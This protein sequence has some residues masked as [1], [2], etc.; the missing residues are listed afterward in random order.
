MVQGLKPT[1]TTKLAGDENLPGY[2]IDGC[3]NGKTDPPDC[4]TEATEPSDTPYGKRAHLFP[5]ISSNG[6]GFVQNVPNLTSPDIYYNDNDH[7]ILSLHRLSRTPIT[8]HIDILQNGTDWKNDSNYGQILYP[9]GKTYDE[10]VGNED[11]MWNDFI[12]NEY[13]SNVSMIN[14]LYYPLDTTS[15]ITKPDANRDEKD[16][17]ES[18]VYVYKW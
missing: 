3:P 14:K 6:L 15:Y 17:L 11:E 16:N 18:V 12:T 10:K 9:W 1:V 5:G 4:A 7:Y 13:P 8:E 2:K